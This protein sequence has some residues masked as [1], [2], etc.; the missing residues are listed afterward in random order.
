LVYFIPFWYIFPHIGIFSPFLVYF[1]PF[2]YIERVK[3][4]N[5]VPAAL[6]SVQF[7]FFVGS[8]TDVMI[9]KIFLPKKLG[10]NIGVFCSNYC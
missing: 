10:E 9:L 2:W 8:G 6:L 3:S 4:G 1:P 7:L 5:P